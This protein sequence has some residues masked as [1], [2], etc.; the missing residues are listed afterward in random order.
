MKICK[1]CGY[2]AE[3]GV[4]TR[5]ET[6]W[7]DLVWGL[8][9]VGGFPMCLDERLPLKQSYVTADPCGLEAKHFVAKE[10]QNAA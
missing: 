6:A 8:T 9:G 3:G 1:D 7:T 10:A 2:F 4:C 5:A